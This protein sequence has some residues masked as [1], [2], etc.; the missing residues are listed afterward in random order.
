MHKAL[1]QD[2]KITRIAQQQ[3]RTERYSIYVDDTYAFSLS[4]TALLDSKLSVGQ[5]VTAKEVEQY[6]L[7][8]ADDKLYAQTLRY[9]AMR[10]R[11][12]W[13]VKNYL[14]RKHASPDLIANLLN[15]LSNNKL[16][17]DLAIAQM[18]VHDRQLLRPASRRKITY[19]LRKKHIPESSIEM[20]LNEIDDLRALHQIIAAKR[21]QSRYRDTNKLLRYLATQGFSYEDIKNALAE[22]DTNDQ[23]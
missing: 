17:D 5:E 3:K 19:E 4:E 18:Y 7:L 21:R 16:V 9:V 13:E 1:L 8:S 23:P 22:A 10:P 15:K 20:A 6:K 14:E 2:M 12:T 11:S